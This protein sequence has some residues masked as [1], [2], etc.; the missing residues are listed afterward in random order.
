MSKVFIEEST[1]TA[2]G[3][4]I[5]DKEGSTAL[6]AP[7]DM[8]TKITNLSTGV[9]PVIEFLDVTE[10]GEYY[11][12]EGVHGFNPVFVDI[13]K[14]EAELGPITITENGTYKAP[15]YD[16]DGFKKVFVEV[17]TGGGDLPEEAFIITGE[18]AYRFANGGFEWLINN[19]GNRIKT[20]NLGSADHMF[21]NMNT[22]EEIPFTLNFGSIYNIVM[23]YMFARIM[24]NH[25]LKRTPA[26]G[27]CRPSE[28]NNLFNNAWWLEE[29]TEDFVNGIDW[30]YMDSQ[31]S[32]YN[33]KQQYMFYGCYA[34]RRVPDEF[35]RHGNPN[36]TNTYSIF[37][38]GV[39]NCYC[40]DEVNF[41]LFYQAAWTSNAFNS[42]FYNCF[43]LK[44]VTFDLQ[45]DG[46]P[47][48]MQWNNQTIDLTSAGFGSGM[49][50]TS[51]L[52]YGAATGIT[53]DKRI[54]DDAS[55]QAL[56]NDPNCYTL[57]SKYSRYNRNSAINTINTLPDCSAYGTNTIKFKGDAGEL[58][59]GGAIN[60]LTEEEIAVATAKGW[61]VTFV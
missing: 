26:I 48:V 16:L 54:L 13:P 30:S 49:Y 23:S 22:V 3:D 5:R 21:Y 53:S 51:I 42:T 34:L 56:K 19:Y 52:N 58:T 32:S 1:L 39:N 6:I 61:T 36:V 35:L 14:V 57:D 45:E 8:A 9:E 43:R 37:Y 50:A 31:T 55:Y 60:T 28:M 18:N 27:Y 44:N 25:P 2:I 46:S 33:C 12:P 38:Y 41:G 59:D 15:D 10:N 47:K 40:L 29:V 4:A 17:P 7:L 11:A 20:E 24:S